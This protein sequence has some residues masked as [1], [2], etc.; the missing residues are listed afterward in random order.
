MEL[1]LDQARRRARELLRAARAGDPAARA[2]MRGDRTPR[3]ADA[4][5][6]VAADLGFPSWPALVGHVEASRGE[7]AERRAIVRETGLSYMPGRPIRVSVRRRGNRYHIDDMGAAVAIAGRPAGWLEAA[8]RA[9]G[10]LGW[11]VNRAGVVFVQ[12]AVGRDIDALVRRTG[13]ASAAV[14]EAVLALD[15]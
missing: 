1:D 9:V 10:E 14:L 6:A 3:L 4:Q 13:E 15:E 12:A 11:N 8:E 7:H 2:R 5:R